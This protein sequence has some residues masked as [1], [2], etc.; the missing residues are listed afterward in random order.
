[1]RKGLQG[2]TQAQSQE[3]AGWSIRGTSGFS[4]IEL[5]LVIALVGI[6][7]T[8]A[9]LGGR[10]IVDRQNE[11]AALRS[12]Q[13]SVWQGATLAASRGQLIELV[14]LN[15]QLV[16]RPTGTST[17]VR[18]YDLPATARLTVD[19]ANVTSGQQLLE[20][21]PPGKVSQSSL[22]AITGLQM[23]FDERVHDIEISLIGEV[24]V[25]N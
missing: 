24:R 4:L 19:G 1:M 10:G 18:S 3:G 20:F 6:I 7:A 12:L 21:T 23:Q 13:Q 5:L 9:V 8:F 16:L 11:N 14:F 22:G 2:A 15:S 17:S 25:A